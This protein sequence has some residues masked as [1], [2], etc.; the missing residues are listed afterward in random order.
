MGNPTVGQ[1]SGAINFWVIRVQLTL[2]LALVLILVASLENEN[3]AVTWSVV[4]RTLQASM[5]PSILSADSAST[6]RVQKG[7]TFITTLSTMGLM[8]LAVAGV[9]TPLGLNEEITL[10][11]T[12]PV[13][14]GYL[15]DTSA[16]G[17][18][19]RSR[20]GYVFSRLCGWWLWRNCPGTSAGYTSF[21]NATLSSLNGPNSSYIDTNVPRNITG[22]FKS[23]TSG[24]GN[25][26]SGPFDVQHRPFRTA[27]DSED[28]GRTQ[29]IEA[30]LR[31]VILDDNFVPVEG[32]AVDAKTG[33][34]GFR[35]HSAP[36]NLRYGG[37]MGQ[38]CV[39]NNFT[40]D[41]TITADFSV[42]NPRLTDRGGWVNL[43]RD[44]P[45]Y[46]HSHSQLDPQLGQ[47]AYEEAWST[48]AIAAW[49][50]DATREA[51]SP[52]KSYPLTA[53]D[54]GGGNSYLTTTISI[55]D[56]NGDPMRGELKGFDT[57]RNFSAANMQCVGSGAGDMS[58]IANI[59]VRCSTFFGTAKRA[60]GGDPGRIYD[61]GSSWSMPIY[62]CATAIKASVKVVTSTMNGT[63][64]TPSRTFASI[65]SFQST[66]PRH[67]Q[68]RYGPWR[69]RM[70]IRDVEPFWGIVDP[71]YKDAPHLWTIEREHLWLPSTYAG[72][73]SLRSFDS[74]GLLDIPSG[75][76]SALGTSLFDD[77]SG[78]RNLALMSKWR[79]LSETQDSVA[80]IPNLIWSDIVANNLVGSK[81]VSSA[82]GVAQGDENSSA[83]E[84]RTVLEN[85]SHIST[86][87]TYIPSFPSLSISPGYRINQMSLAQQ[88]GQNPQPHA[89]PHSH[90]N[91]P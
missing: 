48:N 6:R 11:F 35:N 80:L 7:V 32:L 28:K 71:K 54:P 17:Q 24:H 19:T 64:H 14:F 88:I 75:A 69:T 61:I 52:G 25:L 87:W 51:P 89:N 84:T 70:E 23:A 85:N 39:D 21:T 82:Y 43:V 47:R 12:E 37:T 67:R 38:S 73:F 29:G 41:F 55:R 78:E 53:K 59:A 4:G 45:N 9:V 13:A 66:T 30:A 60:D 31:S 16:F 8:I 65:K 91:L 62:T 81:S 40:I 36:V 83:G 86:T 58:N 46:N 77:Y 5:W 79:E 72:I 1:V 50:P 57:W 74:L 18:A 22:I 68:C 26:I 42:D 63:E 20:S 49:F 90:F 44:R 15:K 33:G 27:K 34:V 10:S 2:P 76:L 56:L 3:N